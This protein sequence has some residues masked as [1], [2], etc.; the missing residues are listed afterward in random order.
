[1]KTPETFKDF[2]LRVHPDPDSMTHIHTGRRTQEY[3]ES[4]Q[5]YKLVEQYVKSMREDA[6]KEM[7]EFVEWHYRLGTVD[8]ISVH[9][10]DGGVSGPRIKTTTELLTQF[11]NKQQDR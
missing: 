3:L 10:S 9:S 4:N 8:R 7:I 2:I 11:R 5:V 1:M 6:E